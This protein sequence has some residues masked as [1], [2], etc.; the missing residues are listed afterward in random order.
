DGK[1]YTINPYLTTQGMKLLTDIVILAG[2][3]LITL[4]V[5]LK[6]HK[7]PISEADI[8]P[9]QVQKVMLG[10]TARMSSDSIDLLFKRILEGTLITSQKCSDVYDT[11]FIGD[12]MHLFKVVAITLKEQCV[13]LL[14][15]L[16]GI[17]KL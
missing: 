14:G 1:V 17:V 10:L 12:Y 9:E 5:Q 15:V 13:G 11:H 2:E 6:S 8:T 3:P 4:A 16:G 7:G